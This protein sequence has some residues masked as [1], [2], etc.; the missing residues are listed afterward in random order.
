MWINDIGLCGPVGRLTWRWGSDKAATRVCSKHS[1][2][3]PGRSQHS[4][5]CDA[6]LEIRSVLRRPV[7]EKGSLSSSVSSVPKYTEDTLVFAFIP[8]NF[9]RRCDFA[10]PLCYHSGRRSRKHVT[11]V[12]VNQI[13]LLSARRWIARNQLEPQL[14]PQKRPLWPSGKASVR[15]PYRVSTISLRLNPL[16]CL[17]P[18][19]LGPIRAPR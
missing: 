7:T 1:R 17:N 8:R 13:R 12:S 18:A 14:F 16:F 15:K 2:P 19:S 9:I 3:P 5:S 4:R 10:L 6:L 11:R